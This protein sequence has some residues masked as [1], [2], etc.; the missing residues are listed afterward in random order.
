MPRARERQGGKAQGQ[1]GIEKELRE[2]K[3]RA[4]TGNGKRKK[5][6]HFRAMDRTATWILAVAAASGSFRGV[7]ANDNGLALTPPLGWRSWNLF[8]SNVNQTLIESIMEG[9]AV[10]KHNNGTTSLCDLGYCDVG[11]DDAWQECDSPDA[12]PGMHYHDDKGNPIVNTTRF[13][14]LKAMTDFA[15]RLNLTAGWYGESMQR[16][17]WP[18]A[19]PLIFWAS[20]Q[21]AL[22]HQ[23]SADDAVFQLCHV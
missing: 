21:L 12:A 4:A 2:A 16:H 3:N 20:G 19:F 6:E 15:H 22:F 10:R 18:Q 1:K 9:M 7:L 5:K 23:P 14:D 8:G 17:A 13:P 11:L